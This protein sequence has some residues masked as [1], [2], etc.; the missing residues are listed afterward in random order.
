MGLP[1]CSGWGVDATSSQAR[2][3]E[4][5]SVFVGKVS[6]KNRAMLSMRLTNR[7]RTSVVLVEVAVHPVMAKVTRVEEEAPCRCVPSL[8][9]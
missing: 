3:V 8:G 1:G 4:G 9:V 5:V 6:T 7:T 2:R